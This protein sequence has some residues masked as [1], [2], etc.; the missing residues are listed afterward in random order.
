[1]CRVSGYEQNTTSLFS[2]P[3]K[4]TLFCVYGCGYESVYMD[5]REGEGEGER[6]REK[7]KVRKEENVSKIIR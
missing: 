3:I 5:E 1:M 7:G 2:Q 6:G 4:K